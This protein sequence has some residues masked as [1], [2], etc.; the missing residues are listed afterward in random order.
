MRAIAPLLA[1]LIVAQPVRAQGAQLSAADI[2]EEA[3]RRAAGF[4]DFTA[5][6]TMTLGEADGT[7]REREMR[8]LGLEV[9]GDGQR[10]LLIFDRPR[11]LLGTS[12]L[13][14]THRNERS[15][16]WLYLP[17]LRRS[18]RIATSDQ[19]DAFMGSQ[20]T[21][22]DMVA[23]EFHRYTYQYLREEEI[24][25]ARAHV[26]ERF[27]TDERSVYG[28]QIIW[29]DIE[30]YLVLRIDYFD[31]SHELVKSLAIEEYQQ[32]A[33]KHW[34]PNRMVM[35]EAR[36]GKSTTLAWSAYAFENGLTEED[37]DPRRLGRPR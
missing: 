27:P 25:R 10:T 5:T 8:V 13:T 33:G 1:L 6:L 24:G 21:Y 23:Q 14:V 26:L 36:S 3:E 18:R 16:Q 2:I 7:E 34:R 31:R 11:D 30:A 37:F 9:P 20:F 12:I 17:A 28:S 22:E 29:L 15:E 35:T 32:Y 4:H 19:S